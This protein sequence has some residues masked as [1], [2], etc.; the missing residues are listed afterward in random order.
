VLAAALVLAAAAPA[1]ASKI[2]GVVPDVPT[3]AHARPPALARA[4]SL[5][6]G[7]GFVLHD[8]RTHLIFWQ[9]S[10]TGLAFDPGYIS[11]TETFLAQVAADSHKPTN[12][13]ALSG[14]YRDTTGP[15]AYASTYGGAVL[16]TDPL[17]ANGC[18][19]PPGPPP[20]GSGPGWAVCLS[21][22]QLEAEIDHV[23]ASRHLPAAGNDIYFLLT[24]NGFGSCTGPGPDN[25]ALG[26]SATGYCGYH[27]QSG[28]GILYAVIPYNA[29][30]GH[31]QSGNPRPNNSTADPTI[32]TISHEHNETVTDPQDDAWID[33]AGNE[34]GDL[35]FTNFGPDLGNSGSSTAW[36]EVIDGGHYYLQEEWSNE[37]GGC[38][39]RDESDPVSFAAPAR[40]NARKPVRFAGHASDPDG[41]IVA[42]TWF[43]GT[44]TETVV[45]R[46]RVL[47]RTFK[48]A[49]TYRITLRTTDR[50]DNWAFTSRTVRVLAARPVAGKRRR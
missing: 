25:C 30:S 12:V 10:G 1:Q 37:A 24:P 19:E 39:P 26:G 36:N 35:C 18:T 49:G 33:P 47:W 44:A 46:S 7:G 8:N 21:D 16:D 11:L 34:D 9:P 50:A 48:R 27:S 15:A 6:Y 31:C 23:V 32:S 17:P 3:G 22:A 38:E 45:G 28:A 41:S 29:I 40:A 2:G 14:Q 4:A 5:D 42:Y 13:Y 20:A 43:L